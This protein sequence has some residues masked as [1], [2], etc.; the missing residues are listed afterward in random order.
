[1]VIVTGRKVRAR[2]LLTQLQRGSQQRVDVDRKLGSDPLVT[3][4]PARAIQEDVIAVL[5]H[6]LHQVI[7]E[8]EVCSGGVKQLPE[9]WVM[10]LDQGFFYLEGTQVQGRVWAFTQMPTPHFKE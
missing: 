6:V 5:G 2:V 3:T 1:M 7:C 10:N 8:P 9:L 4:L